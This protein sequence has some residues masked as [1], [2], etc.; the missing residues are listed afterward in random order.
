MP[1]KTGKV[2]LQCDTCGAT[3]EVYPSVLVYKK[4]MGSKVKFCSREC[5]YEWN[6][7]QV[8]HWKG[9]KMPFYARP[10]KKIK[11]SDNPHWKGGRRVDKDGYIL[12]QAPEHPYRDIDGY[13]REHRLVME[14]SLGRFLNPVE[15]VHHINEIKSDNSLDNLMLFA[16]GAEHIKHHAEI[17]HTKTT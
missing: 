4:K 5:R 2:Q 6:K 9:K 11:G 14:Q 1:K 12:I 13:V 16:S 3:Y 8:G 10:N 7:T 17:R 15:V